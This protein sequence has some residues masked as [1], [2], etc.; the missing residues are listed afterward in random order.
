VRG[1]G[2][3]RRC[4]FRRT[5]GLL[6]ILPQPAHNPPGGV[7]RDR[8]AHTKPIRRSGETLRLMAVHAHPD[9]ESSKGAAEMAQLLGRGRLMSCS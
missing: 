2:P 5:V 7:E 6:D 3:R 8:D 4:A 9:Y 1:R